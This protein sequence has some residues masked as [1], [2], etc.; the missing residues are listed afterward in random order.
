MSH[1]TNCSFS[2]NFKF[3]H[4]LAKVF[5]FWTVVIRTNRAIFTRI[6]LI[7]VLSISY[8]YRAYSKKEDMGSVLVKKGT[9][10]KRKRK[11]KVIRAGKITQTS[12]KYYLIL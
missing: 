12:A 1:T 10:Q 8:L 5:I 2:D 9:D 4:T 7:H 11:R 3:T 6:T